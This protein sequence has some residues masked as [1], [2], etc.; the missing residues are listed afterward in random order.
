MAG[1]LHQLGDQ[2]G[3]DHDLAVLRERLQQEPSALSDRSAADALAKLI[4][5]RQDELQKKALTLG[6]RLYADKPKQ[7]TRQL[8]CHWQEWRR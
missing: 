1:E 2:L 8:H 5:R 4:D 3:D 6:E 7:F